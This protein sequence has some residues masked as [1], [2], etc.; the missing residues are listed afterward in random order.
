MKLLGWVVV[1][2]VLEREA[3]AGTP[4]WTYMPLRRGRVECIATGPAAK[5]LRVEDKV[6]SGG[7]MCALRVTC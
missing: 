4:E 1:V 5:V 6:H 2:V 7:G 3:D